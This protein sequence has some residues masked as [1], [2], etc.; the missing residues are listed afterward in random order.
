MILIGIFYFIRPWDLL[1]GLADRPRVFES[2]PASIEIRSPDPFL[3]PRQLTNP[4]P[5]ANPALE[6]RQSPSFFLQVHSFSNQHSAD[7]ASAGLAQ[8]GY[9]VF[10][11]TVVIDHNSHL[12]VVYVGPFADSKAANEAAA[13]LLRKESLQTVLH[14][15]LPAD[16]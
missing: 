8:K 5:K 13:E 11:R 15:S 14:S 3:P 10:Q 6:P 9:S 2:S 7:Q 4:Q 12:Y 1:H 16:N